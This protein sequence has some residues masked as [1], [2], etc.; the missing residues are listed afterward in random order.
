M[1]VLTTIRP[2]GDGTVLFHGPDGKDVV[3]SGEPGGDLVAEAEDERIL[4][5]LLANDNFQPADEADFDRGQEV[6]NRW[7]NRRASVL[8]TSATDDGAG[9][10]GQGGNDDDDDDEAELTEEQ[11]AKLGPIEA[12]TAPKGGKPRKARPAE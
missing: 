8:G 2:R 7:A 9:E 5:L 6:L 3:F 11:L 10:G 12:G 1:K 4:A